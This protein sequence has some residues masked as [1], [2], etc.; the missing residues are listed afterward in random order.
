[1]E[2]APE[3]DAAVIDLLDGDG[4]GDGGGGGAER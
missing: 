4:D 2:V 1:M 3:G